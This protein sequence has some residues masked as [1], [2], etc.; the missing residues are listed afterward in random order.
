[1][2]LGEKEDAMEE[3]EEEE[4]EEE[5]G[6]A[7]A[8]LQL[9]L[10]PLLPHS[11]QPSFSQLR[12]P[13]A[14]EAGNVELSM[15]GFD[16]NRAPSAGEAEEVAAAASSS[17]NSTVSSFQMEFSAGG[18]EGGALPVERACSRARRLWWGTS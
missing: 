15:R 7:A 10:L 8:P 3:E 13:W 18:G 5:R 14:S 17:P 16:V 2:R 1:M 12:F 11:A 4:E 9:K 6:S